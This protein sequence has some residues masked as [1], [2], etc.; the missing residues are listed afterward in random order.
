MR[1]NTKRLSTD[2]LCSSRYPAKN[3]DRDLGFKGAPAH[4]CCSS[5][6]WALADKRDRVIRSRAAIAGMTLLGL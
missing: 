4:H 6:H 2:R 3:C 1:M 5:I